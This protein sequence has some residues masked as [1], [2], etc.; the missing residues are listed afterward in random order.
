M[1]K[2]QTF[3][4]QPGPTAVTAPKTSRVIK[5]VKAKPRYSE[6]A[7]Q[8]RLQI[9]T[10]RY[11]VA[12]LLPSETDLR[13]EYCVSRHTI[14]EATRQL[15]VAGLVSA[16]HGRGIRVVSNKRAPQTNVVFSSMEGIERYGRIT[17]LVDV[18]YRMIAA[19]EM[20]VREMNCAPGD[21]LLHIQSFREP[22]DR[23]TVTGT[24]WNETYVL[25]KFASIR[26]EVDTWS[27]ALYSLVEQRFGERVVSI[28]QQ[29]TA[30]NLKG[31]VAQRLNVRAGTAGLQVKRTYINASGQPLLMGINT[32]VGSTFTLA[33]EIKS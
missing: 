11:P 28:R 10:G 30:L 26:S 19:E 22:R 32:Y 14:R 24:V 15:A 8:I 1:S 3:S 33:M 4:F 29:V 9:M 2:S 23:S 18:H 17:H 31:K 27:G 12:T 13:L 7:D 25:G 20:L 16:E 6:V 5:A 21:E